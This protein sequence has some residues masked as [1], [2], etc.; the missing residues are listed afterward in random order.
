[1]TVPMRGDTVLPGDTPNPVGQP[2]TTVAVL[3]SAEVGEGPVWSS[4]PGLLYWVDIPAGIVRRDRPFDGDGAHITLPWPVGAVALRAEGGLFFASAAGFG[5]IDDSSEPWRYE[6]RA[7]FS[8]PDYRMNDGKCDSAGRF[9]AGGTAVDFTPGAG[10]LHVVGDDWQVRTELTGL[11]L[12]N[13]MDW[14]PDNTEFYLADTMQHQVFAFEFDLGSGKLGRRRV[15]I[16]FG[17]DG[18][19]PDGLTVDAGGSLWIA[20]WGQGRVLQVRPDGEVMAAV[21]VPVRQPSSCVFGGADYRT[22]FVTTAREGLAVDGGAV[23]GSVLAVSSLDVCGRA[24][25]VFGR[26][27]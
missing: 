24:P 3:A 13:G 2:V 19:M 16:D 10:A 11:T 5:S 20:M 17:A 7:P 27:R 23:D 14:S 25:G 18:G 1:M 15:L 9:W 8:R 12:P 26:P 4:G 6:L 21:E 22:L